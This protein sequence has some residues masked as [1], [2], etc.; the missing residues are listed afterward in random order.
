VKKIK[1]K[2][3]SNWE[4]I[5]LTFVAL[6]GTVLVW[7]VWSG[8]QNPISFGVNIAVMAFAGINVAKFAKM[9]GRQ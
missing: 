2:I 6:A 9:K 8:N 3:V 1:S 4:L 7:W 5:L